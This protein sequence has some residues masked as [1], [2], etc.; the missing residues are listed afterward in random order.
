MKYHINESEYRFMCIV[1]DTEPVNSTELAKLCANRLG[2]K[3]STTYTVIRNLCKKHIISNENAVVK[4][5]VSRKSMQVQESH[6]FLEKRFHGSLPVFITAFL[7]G[8]KLTRDEAEYIQKLIDNA[9]E[10]K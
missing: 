7:E 1:W 5:L 6:D 8:K 3:K 4:S 2:W 10:D 9:V